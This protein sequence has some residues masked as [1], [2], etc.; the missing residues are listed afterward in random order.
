MARF[1]DER[2]DVVGDAGRVHE[3]QRPSLLGQLCHVAAG[4]FA[5]ATL[6]I[7]KTLILH[8]LEV[9]AEGWVNLVENGDA[10][11]DEL[12]RGFKG[13][14]WWPALSIGPDI[15]G[16]EGLQAHLL[17]P[18]L[19]DPSRGRHHLLLDRRMEG[20]AILR[21]VVEAVLLDVGVVAKVLEAGVASY[22]LT[23]AVLL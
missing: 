14:E 4:R 19:E 1:V 5:F 15:P 11:F 23:H 12:L 8:G 13:P 2:H 9:Q 17:T 22:L 7:E 18:S 6:E 10:L 16:P 21:R 20:I 3:D